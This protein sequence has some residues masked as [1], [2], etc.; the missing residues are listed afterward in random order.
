[1]LL[2]NNVCM[3]V[4]VCFGRPVNRLKVQSRYKYLKQKK[5]TPKVDAR[6]NLKLPI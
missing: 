1:M 5:W 2:Y 3:Y 4:L 6:K